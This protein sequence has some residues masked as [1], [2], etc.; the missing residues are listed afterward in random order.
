M[1]STGADELA[2]ELL[3]LT[4]QLQHQLRRHATLGAWA[5]PG[6][7]SPAPEPTGAAAPVEIVDDEPRVPLGRR[8]LAQVRAE[9]GECTRCKL[10]TTRRSIVFGVGAEDA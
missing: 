3:T 2:G 10:H 8:T 7:A 4:R 1:D 6:G 5:V 9:L